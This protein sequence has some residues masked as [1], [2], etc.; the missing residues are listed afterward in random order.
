MIGIDRRLVYAHW[1]LMY[2]WNWANFNQYVAKVWSLLD[3]CILLLD[4]N[5]F[6]LSFLHLLK[7]LNNKMYCVCFSFDVV[8]SLNLFCRS[9][10][11][12]QM[13]LQLSIPWWSLSVPK[14]ARLS[15]QNLYIQIW[16]AMLT[17]CLTLSQS[18][19]I[20][21]IVQWAGGVLILCYIISCLFRS[22]FNTMG[23]KCNIVCRS[24]DMHIN[25]WTGIM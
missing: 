22:N 8:L 17:F 15:T 2:T 9:K 6:F 25:K 16:K 4:N 10:W 12:F 14:V 3:S 20:L 1:C 23:C 24:N 19:W 7:C 5:C 11:N 13:A 18:Y 21:Y